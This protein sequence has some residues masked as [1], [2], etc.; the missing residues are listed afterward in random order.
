MV[1]LSASDALRPVED[2]VEH[3]VAA[4][5]RRSCRNTVESSRFETSDMTV[6]VTV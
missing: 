5:G 2:L 3:L 4:H 6:G 1:G